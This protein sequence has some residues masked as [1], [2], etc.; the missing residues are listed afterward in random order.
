MKRENIYQQKEC[1]EGWEGVSGTR[2]LIQKFSD[3]FTIL[4]YT[5]EMNKSL[6]QLNVPSIP[7]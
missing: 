3:I 2:E 6:K 1:N 4:L 7:L 5:T